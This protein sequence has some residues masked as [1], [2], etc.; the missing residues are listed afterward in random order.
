[1]KQDKFTIGIIVLTAAVVIAGASF[2][3]KTILANVEG[4]ASDQ[5][6]EQMKQAVEDKDF[7]AWKN[8]ISERA[9]K[10]L[11]SATEENFAT[12]IEVH[13]LMKDGK[14][15]E[16]KQLMKDAD[17][18]VMGHKMKGMKGGMDPETRDAMREVLDNA[19]FEAFKELM[20]DKP[21]ADELT[22]EVFSKFVEAHQ[23]REAGDHEGARAIKEEL[24]FDKMKGPGPEEGCDCT[25]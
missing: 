10:M 5:P 22:E 2:A 12:M 20:G 14:Y 3:A 11:G 24:G 9:N 23:L 16:A 19:D 25:E 8:L 17:L 6:H 1:M 15:E 13:Q 18:G 4:E 21:M 7:G